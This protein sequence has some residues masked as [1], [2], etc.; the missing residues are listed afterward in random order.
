MSSFLVIYP[1]PTKGGSRTAIDLR[2]CSMTF[3]KSFN[4]ALFV[5]TQYFFKPPLVGLGVKKV[6]CAIPSVTTRRCE[7]RLDPMKIT[8]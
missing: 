4:F 1:L 8:L 7:S 6:E 2:I 3:W 5:I